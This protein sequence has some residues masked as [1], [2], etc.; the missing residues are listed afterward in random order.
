MAVWRNSVVIPPTTARKPLGTC[1]FGASEGANAHLQWTWA[2]LVGGRHLH[3]HWLIYNA[4]FAPFHDN[5]AWITLHL[6]RDFD[7]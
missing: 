1:C 4:F 2:G 5:F 7:L 6:S 3:F